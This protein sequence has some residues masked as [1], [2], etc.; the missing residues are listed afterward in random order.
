MVNSVETKIVPMTETT[1]VLYG[2]SGFQNI[3]WFGCSLMVV[4]YLLKLFD[5]VFLGH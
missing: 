3:S 1:D 2:Y 5:K 4:A